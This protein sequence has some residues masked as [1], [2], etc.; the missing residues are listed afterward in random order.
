[1][2]LTTEDECKNAAISLSLEYLKS[3]VASSYPKGCYKII[4]VYWNT[5]ETG[6]RQSGSYPICKEISKL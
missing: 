5:H 6:Q 4:D 1:M 2:D 3:E